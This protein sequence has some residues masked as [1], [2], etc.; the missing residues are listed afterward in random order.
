MLENAS[1]CIAS[2]VQMQS[3]AGPGVC[4]SEIGKV[5]FA[6]LL[7]FIG[8]EHHPKFTPSYL[9]GSWPWAMAKIQYLRHQKLPFISELVKELEHLPIAGHNTML[10]AWSWRCPWNE[11]LIPQPFQQFKVM[12][13]GKII[14]VGIF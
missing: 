5:N 2:R 6:E 9:L 10:D 14:P 12:F 13:T 4:W 7:H 3:G 1:H 11:L 8:W